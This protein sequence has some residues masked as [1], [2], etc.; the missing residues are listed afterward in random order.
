MKKPTN[1]SE[2]EQLLS[3]EGSENIN[4]YWRM[5]D[6]SGETA[7]SYDVILE[8]NQT[9]FSRKKRKLKLTREKK[10]LKEEVTE[11]TLV[12][13][14]DLTSRHEKMEERRFNR[15]RANQES[16]TEWENGK[17]REEMAEGENQNRDGSTE[18][19]IVE[20]EMEFWNVVI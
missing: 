17:E 10:S 18:N 16:K 14:L 3:S 9:K 15:G 2:Q 11:Q 20:W 5:E 4:F 7:G 1:G 8:G 12:V 19:C 13:E 6:Q